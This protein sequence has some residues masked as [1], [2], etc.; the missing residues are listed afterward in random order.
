MRNLG[1]AE[2]RSRMPQDDLW[3]IDPPGSRQSRYS[4]LVAKVQTTLEA[5]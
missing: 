5:A 2:E 3:G 1:M 4:E